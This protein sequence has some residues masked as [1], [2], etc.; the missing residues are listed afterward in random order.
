MLLRAVFVCRGE[1]MKLGLELDMNKA[2][3]TVDRFR[4]GFNCSQAVVVSYSEEF[5]VDIEVAAKMATGFGGGMRMGETC[6]A[7]TG[8]FMV[9]GLKCGNATAEDKEA[10]SATYKLVKDFTKRFKERNGS[11]LCKELLGFNLST[12]AGMEGAQE[13]GVFS[14]TCPKM[15]QEAVEILEEMLRE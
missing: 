15:V 8:A 1:R 14:S 12:P 4:T 2:G 3:C 9:L 7:V 13:K 6:G 10:K 11:V 5:G